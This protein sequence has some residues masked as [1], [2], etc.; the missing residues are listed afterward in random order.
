M[1]DFCLQE[2]ITVIVDASHP[3][4]VEVSQNAIA[5]AKINSIPYLRFEREEL[6]TTEI[7]NNLNKNIHQSQKLIIKLDSWETLIAGN[8]LKDKRVLLTVGCKALPLFKSWQNHAILFT[9]ILPKRESLEIA[10]A[11]GFT[12]NR[13]IAI[14]PPINKE[15]ELALCQ[16][17]QISLI[18]TKASGKPGGEDIKREVAT[19]LGI[20]LIVIARPQIIYPQ[21]TSCLDEAIAF[22]RQYLSL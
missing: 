17:W 3:Y 13:I 16:Q 8:Y 20:P 15:L 7:L 12:T 10:I 1:K 9:R 19:E 14:R 22:C 2:N 18:V 11:S 4:A 6:E 5:T 21:Q